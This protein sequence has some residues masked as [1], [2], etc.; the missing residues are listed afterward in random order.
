ME[1]TLIE[2]IIAHI[3]GHKY[4]VNII[5]TRGV[6]KFEATSFIH[7]TKEQADAHRLDIENTRSF[8]FIE[9]VS[10]RSRNVYVNK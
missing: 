3:F 2:K 6:Q 8:A 1:Q 7:R 9:T 5:R 4:Y 10:F